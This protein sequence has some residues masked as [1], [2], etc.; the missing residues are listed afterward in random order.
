AESFKV[1]DVIHM[2]T[3]AVEPMLKDGKVRLVKEI[4]PDLPPLNTDREKLKQIILNL[5]SNAAKFT[6]QGEIRVAAW[7]E[8]SSM[9]ITVADTGISMRSE[10][11]RVGKESRDRESRYERRISSKK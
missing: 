5:L 2:V 1:D 6:E 10:E 11:R 4:A 9:K 3:S 7:R 8:D